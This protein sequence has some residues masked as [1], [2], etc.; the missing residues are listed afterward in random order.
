MPT[1]A[2][3]CNDCGHEFEVRQRMADDPLTECPNC[4]GTI[5]RVVT[6]VGV[7]FKG[8]GFYITDNRG[9]NSATVPPAPSSS[10]DNKTE[11]SSSDKPADTAASK[12]DKPKSE[13]KTKTAT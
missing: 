4:A 2:Y 1:Y 9:S 6:S 11:G 8:S 3:R 12:P 10:S 13:A 5:R 7:V